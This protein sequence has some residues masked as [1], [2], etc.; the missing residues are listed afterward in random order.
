MF[1]RFCGNALDFEGQKFCTHCGAPVGLEKT[2]KSRSKAAEY[3]LA[4]LKAAGWFLIFFAVSN[5]VTSVYTAIVTAS[6]AGSG[7]SLIDPNG[8]QG[9]SDGFWR[10]FSKNVCWVMTLGYALVI[11]VYYIIFRTRKK[12]LAEAVGFRR[13]RASALPAAY[14]Y[15]IGLE[16]VAVL[17]IGILATFIPAVI[18]STENTDQVYNSMFM[19]SS[20]LSQFI[21]TVP[22]TAVME[23]LV[24]RGFIYNTLKKSMPQMAASLLCAVAFGLAHTGGVQFVYTA[25]LSIVMVALY[26]KYNSLW[27]CIF[28]H[29]GFNS[30]S[31][32]IMFIDTENWLVAMAMFCLGIGMALIASAY[33]FASEPVYKEIPAKEK[34][35]YEA[36]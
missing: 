21:F 22:V 16:V 12:S 30:V 19:S 5:I 11:L 10:V 14:F 13:M 9:M 15:G 8:Y 36:L 24:F 33:F 2:K 7:A 3:F 26:E 35:D 23:E 32:L 29:A 17:I 20:V 6:Y 27:V 31:V 1:C 28:L 4:I 34:I 25:L 18:E